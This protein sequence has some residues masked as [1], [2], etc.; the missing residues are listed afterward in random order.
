MSSRTSY[1]ILSSYHFRMNL[2]ALFNL[3][4]LETSINSLKFLIDKIRIKCSMWNRFHRFPSVFE[5][6]ERESSGFNSRNK[7]TVSPFVIQN[8]LIN[9]GRYV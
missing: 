6:S 1:F 2:Y 7:G 3:K 5:D 4:P 9:I 8:S